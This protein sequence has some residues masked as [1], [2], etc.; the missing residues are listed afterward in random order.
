MNTKNT[1]TNDFCSIQH[2]D[3]GKLKQFER[4]EDDQI[5]PLLASRKYFNFVTTFFRTKLE[6]FL[7]EFKMRIDEALIS[8]NEEVWSTLVEDCKKLLKPVW[9][10]EK[11]KAGYSKEQLKEHG[12]AKNQSQAMFN[13]VCVILFWRH[14]F[15]KKR[16][17]NAVKSLDE[18]RALYESDE[19]FCKER[20]DN[21]STLFQFR[22][23]MIL[24]AALKPTFRNKGTFTK[25]ACI[26]AEDRIH[27]TG[28]GQSFAADRR[29][30]IYEQEGQVFSSIAY[31]NQFSRCEKNNGEILGFENFMIHFE[32]ESNSN[33]AEIESVTSNIIDL[34]HESRTHKRHAPVSRNASDNYSATIV[35]PMLSINNSA[36]KKICSE[37]ESSSIPM[38]AYCCNNSLM[39]EQEQSGLPPKV[40]SLDDLLSSAPPMGGSADDSRVQGLHPNADEELCQYDELTEHYYRCAGTAHVEP[41]GYFKETEN[42]SS[43]HYC[44]SSPPLGATV[45]VKQEKEFNRCGAGARGDLNFDPDVFDGF[46][47]F[48]GVGRSDTTQS[49]IDYKDMLSSDICLGLGLDEEGKEE[50]LITDESFFIN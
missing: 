25:L 23:V 41:A 14:P 15:A 26:L 49:F 48:R 17:L 36:K 27:S 46:E 8:N 21:W 13:C 28:G 10:V 40:L 47:E 32:C 19:K 30:Y 34:D 11:L 5:V 43:H 6:E 39:F 7:P 29:G 4:I 35:N 24:A 2:F 44:I 42:E 50:V 22:N 18:F 9:K 31:E 45:R 16:F 12:F 3:V 1:L 33:C 20:M 37:L 38:P